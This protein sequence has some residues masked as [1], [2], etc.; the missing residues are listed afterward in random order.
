ALDV[1]KARNIAEPHLPR[2]RP[3]EAFYFA[4]TG[5]ARALG[6]SATIG[7]LDVGK[8][9]DL[10]LVDLPALLPYGKIGHGLDDLTTEDVLAVCIYRGG[11]HATRET[12]VRGK[13]VYR[14]PD[15]AIST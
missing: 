8:E 9:A 2:L 15:S 10:L 5:G 4:T 11:P 3:S 14:A 7:S 13:C 12:Y 6:K 1:Q